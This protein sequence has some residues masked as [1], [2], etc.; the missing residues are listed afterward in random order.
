MD[1]ECNALLKLQIH[2]VYPNVEDLVLIDLKRLLPKKYKFFKWSKQII[3]FWG[4]DWSNG[5]SKSPGAIVITR[6]PLSAKS[7]AK[8]KVIETIAPLE[9]A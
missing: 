4:N 7:R 3:A 5:V 1:F 9:A 2:L 6:I 8:G